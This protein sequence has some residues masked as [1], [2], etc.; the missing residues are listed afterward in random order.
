MRTLLIRRL[1]PLLALVAILASACGTVTESPAAT[2]NGTRITIAS[3]QAELTTI[4][5]NKAYRG[6]LEQSYGMKLAGTGKGTF[7]SAFV[8]QL[9]SLR[10]YYELL[11]QSLA[12][13]GVKI[14]A[15]DD[16]KALTTIEQQL[17]SLGKD[18]P[19]AFSAE[20]RKRLAHQQA[21]IEK[22]QDEAQNGD[23]ATK[24]FAAHRDEFTQA[25]VSHILISKDSHTPAEA[26][27]L[28]EGI[29]AQ[30]DGGA[31]FATVAKATSE[32][33]GS[34]DTGGDL[35][36]GPSGRF[37]PA[38]DAAVF[39]LPIGKVSPPV[40]TDFGYHLI[41]VRSRSAAKLDDVREQ[42]GPKALDAFLLELTCGRKSKIDV[43]P[44]YG[45][46][47]RAA[48]KGD[49]GLGKVSPPPQPQSD[50]TTTTDPSLT[51]APSAP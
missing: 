45:T 28:A 47:D 30:L 41:L 49:A 7:G 14:S 12:D 16:S 27:A 21:L 23:L 11:E 44:R 13:Q 1:A 46:W 2:V 3:V 15:S 31:D 18:A 51:T 25:C 50:R 22:A 37:V 9:L 10:V 32:D 36:C 34:K 26:K 17:G 35:D 6:A 48:C 42:L 20:Y 40:K 4:R 29:K 39:S 33:A 43:N 24:Y 38:F 8:A 5:D 19:K